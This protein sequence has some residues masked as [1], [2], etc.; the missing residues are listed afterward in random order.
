[1]GRLSRNNSLTGDDI[2]LVDD[3]EEKRM[4]RFQLKVRWKAEVERVEVE[5]DM[6]MGKVMDELASM[7]GATAGHIVLYKGQEQVKRE[8]TVAGLGKYH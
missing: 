8:D 1:M 7:V 4:Q 3:D 2:L 5:P 6:R